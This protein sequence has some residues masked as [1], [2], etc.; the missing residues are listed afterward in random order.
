MSCDQILPMFWSHLVR[1]ELSHHFQCPVQFLTVTTHLSISHRW[2]IPFPCNI[3]RVSSHFSRF[4]RI[5]TSW[6]V[7]E[8]LDGNRTVK[9]LSI[10][11]YI[12][13]RLMLIPNPNRSTVLVLERQVMNKLHFFFIG[14]AYQ[15][16]LK[17]LTRQI[18]ADN[19]NLSTT[20]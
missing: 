13:A 18:S 11:P 2:N 19:R 6:H 20:L 12:S 15:V 5:S 9:R 10:V 17:L 3:L 4:Q 7:A 14:Y 8:P 1:S 16:S